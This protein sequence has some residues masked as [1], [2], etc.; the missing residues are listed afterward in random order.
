MGGYKTRSYSGCFIMSLAAILAEIEAATAVQI[1]AL[2]QETEATIQA[3]LAEARLAAAARYEA[4]RL[5][6]V[7]PVAVERAQ[8][9]YEARLAA[10]RAA[11]AAH[12]HL[13][14]QVQ[15]EAQHHLAHLRHE[16]AYGPILH[17]LI[18]EALQALGAEETAQ[19][20]ID[21]R[22]EERVAA[23]LGEM[24]LPIPSKPTLNSWGGVVVQSADG[25]ITIHNTL[26]SRLERAMSYVEL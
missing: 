17:N 10:E 8:R 15:S 25:R 9:L 20:V 23:I 11:A 21:P 22:D 18:A 4:A 24:A 26:E 2:Q 1:A 5:A 14:Q 12:V 19:L 7:R 6:V 3:I 16:P 13:H